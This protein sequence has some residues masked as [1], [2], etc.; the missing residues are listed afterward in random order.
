VLNYYAFLLH[1]AEKGG[2]STVLIIAIVILI[3]V[4]IVLFFTGFCFLRRRAIKIDSVP[5]NDGKEH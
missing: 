2:V 3:A 1:C 5:E 4:S